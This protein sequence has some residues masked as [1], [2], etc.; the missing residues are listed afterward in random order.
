LVFYE[1]ITMIRLPSVGI[2]TGY[3]SVKA[4]VIT[5]AEGE[6]TF[7]FESQ[8]ARVSE[9]TRKEDKGAQKMWIVKDGE[10]WYQANGGDADDG[11][12]TMS[13]TYFET[14]E[15]RALTKIMMATIAVETDATHIT[16]LVLGLPVSQYAAIKNR[17]KLI[18]AFS[19]CHEIYHGGVKRTI[20]VTKVE[21]I[22]QPGGALASFYSQ[23]DKEAEV[24]ALV[25]VLDVG[26]GTTDYIQS[27]D[28]KI[29]TDKSKSVP[30]AMSELRNDV[31][32]K[33]AQSGILG[34]TAETVHDV[35][36]G[37]QVF[38]EGRQIKA[39]DLNPHLERQA[40]K[41]ILKLLTLI[42]IPE[43]CTLVL[44]GAAAHFLAPFVR[45]AVPKTVTIYVGESPA[46]QNAKGFALY[47]WEPTLED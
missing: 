43:L 38:L 25:A 22:P 40:N 37:R 6:R 39:K 10:D 2:D 28:M 4:W 11:Y 8:V 27:R 9:P 46:F 16:K 13:L 26:N 24:P 17:A 23:I 7:T 33:V 36:C 15:Y 29:Q 32:A 1:E 44:T 18:E 42:K 34:V 19:G 35:L 31:A 3:G 41:L 14:P 47:G 45:S 21:I 30:I 12:R 20:E 5:P